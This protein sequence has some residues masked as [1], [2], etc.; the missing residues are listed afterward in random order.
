[1]IKLERID[2]F[3]MRVADVE[4]TCGFYEKVLGMEVITFD[5]K[6]GVVRKALAASIKSI[7]TRTTQLVSRQ[8][9]ALWR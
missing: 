4:A 3:V 7:C 5:G 2:Q 6:D 8:R 1:M 9:P